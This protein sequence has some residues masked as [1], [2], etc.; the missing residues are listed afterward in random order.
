M[1]RRGR[2]TALALRRAGTVGI[3]LG[4]LL[5]G[6]RAAGDGAFPGSSGIVAPTT[7]P[8]EIVLGT[9]FGVVTSI[10]DGQTW[11]YACEQ[12]QSSLASQYQLGAPPLSRLY[13]LSDA[14]WCS[15]TTAGAA[16]ASRAAR[17]LAIS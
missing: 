12:D 7:R 9:N 5:A 16:G 6:G 17:S 15:P 1:Q 13:A 2:V 11:T 4:S 14:G 8:H 10:D 3:C